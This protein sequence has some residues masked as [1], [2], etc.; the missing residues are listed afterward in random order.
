MPNFKVFGV[1]L[2]IILFYFIAQFAILKLFGN[3]LDFFAHPMIFVAI[4]STALLFMISTFLPFI[5]GKILRYV[6]Y[7][8]LFIFV[9]L[10]EINLL[11]TFIQQYP[12]SQIMLEKC[13]S[14]FG[15]KETPTKITDAIAIWSC[16]TNGYFPIEVG[17]LGW[18]VFAVFYLIL[19]FAFVFTF[20]YGI[21]S[22]VGVEDLLGNVGRSVTL[23]LSFI[24][25]MYASRQLFGFFL[26]DMYGYGVWGLIGVFGAVLFVKALQY[27]VE[28]WFKLEEYTKN[29][30]D[31]IKTGLEIEKN[32]KAALLTYINKIKG[33]KGAV[34]NNALLSIK[35][36]K[37]SPQYQA[38][39]NLGFVLQGE[40]DRIINEIISGKKNINDLIKLLK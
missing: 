29:L 37:G 18:T 23:I 5:W 35:G 24:I 3:Q 8:F 40:V 15:T 6:G 13:T 11:K 36:S 30:Q 34:L 32:A 31:A 1:G 7:F 38:Y 19:P 25:S 28:N 10:L 21:M 9:L 27:M 4:V 2:G 16:T 20:M 14:L 22:K 39:S 12:S 17:D 26:L 33:Y